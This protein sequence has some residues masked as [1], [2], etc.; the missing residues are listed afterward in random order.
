VGLLI[1]DRSL[2]D[3][4]EHRRDEHSRDVVWEKFHM[5]SSFAQN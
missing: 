3:V 2:L 5:T 1:C 4:T